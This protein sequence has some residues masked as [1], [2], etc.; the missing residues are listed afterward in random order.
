MPKEETLTLKTTDDQFH[1]IETKSILK[2]A[3]PVLEMQAE[4]VQ[5]EYTVASFY[6]SRRKPIKDSQMSKAPR[7]G[8]RKNRQEL[9]LQSK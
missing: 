8:S 9:P 6:A 2:I 1:S 3:A 7:S 5:V 4:T